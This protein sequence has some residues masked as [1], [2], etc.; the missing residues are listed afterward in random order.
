MLDK[1][2]M[3]I[4][5]D[6]SLVDVRED[7]KYCIFGFDLLDLDLNV[8]SR[9]VYKDDEGLIKHKALSHAYSRL[10]TSFTEMAFKFFHE[11]HY[12]PY[13]ELKCSPAK[14]LQ[15]HNVYGTDWIE[16]GA[17]EMLGY[18]AVT[19]PTLYGMLAISE[20]EVKQLDAT[21]SIRLRDNREVE[22]VLDFMRNM[23]TQYIRKPKKSKSSIF[24]ENTV[25]FSVN[26]KSFDRKAYGK[27]CEF[28]DQLDDLAKLAKK[29]DKAAQRL[30]AVMSDPELQR[31]AKGLLRLETGVKAF[32]LRKFN[33]PTNLFQLIRYQRENPNFL[34]NLWVHA[35]RQLFKA[36]EGHTMKLLDDE[37]IRKQIF[38]NFKKVRSQDKISSTKADR[39]FRFYLHLQDHGHNTTKKLMKISILFILVN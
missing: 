12:W 30:V 6:S 38:I 8:F 10:P 4:P 11:G 19:Y 29:N 2:V 39:V 7:G 27:F 16:Q 31:F 5:V 3:H 22:Q 24:Y 9:S 15:G 36:F 32:A 26:S 21:Y 33:I 34:C 1:I 20:T 14:I 13:V 17:M 25:Y 35:N 18:L 37:S 28:I 23:S